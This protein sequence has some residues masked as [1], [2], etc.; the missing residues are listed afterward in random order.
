[1]PDRDEP[2]L[3]EGTVRLLR[4]DRGIWVSAEVNSR[5]PCICSRC[6]SD[7]ECTVDMRIEEEFFPLVDPFTGAVVQASERDDGG[8]RIDQ[9]HILDLTDAVTQY[10]LIGVPMKPVCREDCAGLCPT[11][12]ADLNDAPCHCEKEMG[13]ARWGPLLDLVA[14]DRIGTN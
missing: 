12:G 5:A 3:L 8:F 7:F 4:T 9:D 14:G 11:C 1:M 13:D 6:L 10:F 2:R